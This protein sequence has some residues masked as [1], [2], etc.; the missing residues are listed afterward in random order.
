MPIP[1]TQT[2]ESQTASNPFVLAPKYANFKETE[3]KRP[4]F[5]SVAP[6]TVSKTPDPAWK[7]GD[8]V[9]DK[10]SLSKE[11]VEIDPFKPGRPMMS[12]YKLLI[13]GVPRPISFISTQSNGGRPNLAPFSYF[14]VVDHDPPIFVVGFSARQARP[15]DT[16]KNL[17]ETGECVINV[18]SEHMIEA[19]NATSIDVPDGVSEWALSGLHPASSTTVKPDRVKEAVFSIEGI[20]K[21]II[22]LDY[23]GKAEIGKATGSLAIIEAK[24]FWVREDAVVG[25]GEGVELG[26]LRPLVQLGGMS[27]GR[28]RETF[29]L[30]R[31]SFAG[32][33]GDEKSELGNFL[34]SNSVPK[35]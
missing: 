24:R 29:E 21:E 33:M 16:L 22:E 9:S 30:P 15:K 11:H 35:S 23:H 25:D 28:V 12:N 26:V 20:L 7:Y 14:Q 3:S 2:R 5:E 8:G 19:V 34:G 13:S 32:E 31:K 27:Y 1:P 6:I 17:R 18:V 4:P 10:A